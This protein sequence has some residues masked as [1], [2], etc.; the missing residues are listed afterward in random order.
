MFKYLPR[1]SLV[2]RV[3]KS[4]GMVWLVLM[5]TGLQRTAGRLFQ[6]LLI[7][8]LIVGPACHLDIYYPF[9]ALSIIWNRPAHRTSWRS[10]AKVVR[11]IIRSSAEFTLISIGKLESPGRQHCQ[12]DNAQNET[13]FRMANHIICGF[14]LMLA[15]GRNTRHLT[16]GNEYRQA[17]CLLISETWVRLLMSTGRCMGFRWRWAQGADCSAELFWTFQVKTRKARKH[18]VH[19]HSIDIVS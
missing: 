6:S 1:R 12:Q 18:G 4:N 7:E 3:V 14:V 15:F 16:A 2:K 8:L 19:C 11:A 10:P 5:T 9:S 17:V 13:L